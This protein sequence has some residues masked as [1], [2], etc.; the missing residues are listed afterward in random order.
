M[1]KIHKNKIYFIPPGQ[2]GSSLVELLIAMAIFS[3][4]ASSTVVLVINNFLNERVGGE[5]TQAATF[6][7]EGAA[8]IE[9][10]ADQAWSGL[11]WNAG[12]ANHGVTNDG[13]TWVLDGTENVKGLDD[14]YTRQ[15]TVDDVYRDGGGQGDIVDVSEPGATLDLHTKMLTVTTGWDITPVRSK[16][17]SLTSYLTNWDS[18]N[19]VQTDWSGGSGQSIWSASSQYWTDDGNIE[20]TVTGQATLAEVTSESDY[21]WDFE[22]SADYTV[23]DPIE[24]EVDAG[25]AHLI[26]AGGAVTG[27]TLN[28]DFSIKFSDWNFST[29]TAL[30]SSQWL[31]NG[32]NPGQYVSIRMP[33]TRTGTGGGYWE[34]SF[35]VTADTI[36]AATLDF[37]YSMVDFADVDTTSITAYVF[38]D[39]V[40]GSPNILDAVWFQDFTAATSWSSASTIDLSSYITGS[41]TFYLKLAFWI[42]YGGSG[43]DGQFTLGYDNAEVNWEGEENSYPTTIPTVENSTAW[44]PEFISMINSFAETAT[45]D[46]GAE[47]YYQLSTDDG[48][49]W[50]YWD[51]AAW[52]TAGTTD[53]NTATEVNDN[54]QTF[55]MGDKDI[56][57]KAHFESDGDA[58]AELDQIDIEYNPD[59]ITM[60]VGSATLESGDTVTMEAD[61]VSGVSGSGWTTVTFTNTNFT[62]PVVVTSQVENNNT[63]PVSV[64]IRNVSST[65]FD[66]TLQAPDGSSPA[67]EDVAYLAVE[68]GSWSVSGHNIEADSAY[69]S[70]VAASSAV[71]GTWAGDNKSYSL[72]YSSNP[73]VMHQVQTAGDTDWIDSWVSQQSS[74]TNPPNTSGFQISMNGAQATS[75]H[76]GETVGWIV[77]DSGISG[78]VGGVTFETQTTSDSVA[79]HDNGCYTFSYSTVNSSS[80]FTISDQLEMDGSDGSWSAVC[81]QAP[82]SV[83][84]HAEEDQEYDSERAHTSE[85]FGFMAFA[86]S[87]VATDTGATGW[88]TISLEQSYD[89]PV[90]A[91]LPFE[92][93]TTNPISAR[94][95]NITSNSFDVTL[96]ES[97]SDIGKSDTIHYIVVEEG[98]WT[99]GNTK[100]EAHQESISTVGASSAVGGTWAGDSKTYSQT[101]SANPIVLHQVMSYNDADWIT[102]WVSSD[103]TQTNPPDTSGFQIAMNGAQVT[104]THDPETIGWIVF[105][106][107]GTDTVDGTEFRTSIPGTEMYGHDN[108]C[109]TYTHGGTYTSPIVAASQLEMDGGDGGWIRGCSLG[110]TSVGFHCEEDQEYDTERAHTSEILG[111][112]VFEEAFSIN[113]E[114]SGFA[115]S[116]TLES[117]SFGPYSNFNTIQWSDTIPGGCSG[118]AIQLQIKTAPDA[119]GVPGAWSS[120]WAGPT[121]AGSYYTDSSEQLIPETHLQEKWI[122]YLVTFSSDGGGTPILEDVSINYNP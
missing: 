74:I 116:G 53:Y 29:W 106:N 87:A 62:D 19:W 54:I 46:A 23:S 78:T 8:A 91:V 90:I 118:C 7:L 93:S 6:N 88:T 43:R 9:N 32:G 31:N 16:E 35:D 55:S 113:G 24:V 57:F 110:S 100:V 5:I 94:I 65:G 18:D 98:A 42:D 107:Y 86:S 56:K 75:T 15:I 105:E 26:N 30:G 80:A 13:S 85:T 45:K 83:G 20:T 49:T 70:T 52:S 40:S 12:G 3:L 120:D 112:I 73:V 33:R 59:N 121:G 10:I 89:S 14:K 1:S 66:V 72:G 69:T 44:E 82:T 115:T 11:A 28:A 4:L 39:T 36:T 58:Q 81:S 71:G 117:S 111:Y 50:Q 79:G 102:S 95:D 2:L 17:L 122:R 51:G 84:V 68:R 25:T 92:D 61:T 63:S 119:A 48:V 103:G 22:T 97:N 64:R 27:Q 96:Q 67:A 34:Q 60:E 47:I 109:S 114:T 108:G 38:V 104:S 99:L 37:D 21:T 76:G 101:Y 77:V 41:G